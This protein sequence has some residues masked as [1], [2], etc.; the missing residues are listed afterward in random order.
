[1][2]EQAGVRLPLKLELKTSTDA[3]RVRLATILQAQMRAAGIDLQ[4]HS[5]DWGTYFD[6][7]KHGKFQLYGLTWVGI[8][9]P[10]IYRLA[11][12]SQSI[13]PAGANR[14]RLQDAT[15]D[16][17]IDAEDWPAATQRIHALM[18]YVPLWYE[19]QFAAVHEGIR[20]YQ[21]A[22]DGNWDA[23]ATIHKAKESTP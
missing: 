13:P 12:H 7:V 18:P 11:F 1:M 19:G 15:L 23:L 20:N 14:G 21:P 2:L 9:T 8:R 22:P 10:E 5:L 6:D 4:I 17:L 16:G 3:Q